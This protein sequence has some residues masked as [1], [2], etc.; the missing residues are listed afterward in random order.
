MAHDIFIP[1]LLRNLTQGADVVQ[2]N[3]ATVGEIILNIDAR[4]PGFR[5]RICD[6][7]GELRQFI[8]VF[9]N[10]EDVRFLDDLATVVPDGAEVSIVPA[11]AGG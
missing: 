9:L 10:G 7:R 3:A 1:T 4:F 5:N 8:N 11:I 6:D 2:V